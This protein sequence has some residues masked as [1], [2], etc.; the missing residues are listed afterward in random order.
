MVTSITAPNLIAGEIASLPEIFT[1]AMILLFISMVIGCILIII[2]I[3][4][5]MFNKFRISFLSISFG[6]LSL[7]SPVFIFYYAMSELTKVGVGGFFGTGDLDISLI[8]ESLRTTVSS[9]W[10]PGIGFYFCLTAAIIVLII[11][12][13]NFKIILKE[14]K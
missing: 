4:L 3:F 2:N 11:A 7:I 14:R 13:F 1:N 8:G 5:E 10:G 12:F 6:A 9:S